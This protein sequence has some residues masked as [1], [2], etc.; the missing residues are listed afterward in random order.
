MHKCARVRR[1]IDIQARLRQQAAFVVQGA[2]KHAHPGGVFKGASGVHLEP[3][4][5][6]EG[7]DVAFIAARA[8]QKAQPH[9]LAGFAGAAARPGAD[10]LRHDFQAQ[11]GGQGA[12]S[13]RIPPGS[14]DRGGRQKLLVVPA[15]HAIEQHGFTT[16]RQQCRDGP[17]CLLHAS[18][19]GAP[20]ISEALL[21]PKANELLMTMWR[22]CPGKAWPGPVRFRRGR[23]GSA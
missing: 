6:R 15:G 3:H 17:G 14:P 2:G 21:P 18:G 20:K 8:Q 23:R 19:S 7:I 13:L 12:I 22:P 11:P 4:A 9:R 1:A 10:G 5:G 16:M